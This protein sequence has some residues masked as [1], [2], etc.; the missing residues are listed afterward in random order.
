MQVQLNISV[1]VYIFET[2]NY[3]VTCL[4]SLHHCALTD[5]QWMLAAIPLLFSYSKV[6]ES[7][8]S[9]PTV[10]SPLQPVALCC[11]FIIKNDNFDCIFA[12][13]NLIGFEVYSGTSGLYYKFSPE[14]EGRAREKGDDMRQRAKT[15]TGTQ[16]GCSEGLQLLY[17]GACSTSW[18]SCIYFWRSLVFSDTFPQECLPLQNPLVNHVRF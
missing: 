2:I 3:T 1:Y 12:G 17:T 15:G 8:L 10:H 5:S 7:P 9:S 6:V 18:A 4:C 16:T 11:Q 14:N 13:L